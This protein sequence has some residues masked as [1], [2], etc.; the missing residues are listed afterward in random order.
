MS[1]LVWLVVPVVGGVLLW[2]LAAI[3]ESKWESD[4][5]EEW[6]E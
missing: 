6:G 4:I 2:M 5:D 3:G 1:W